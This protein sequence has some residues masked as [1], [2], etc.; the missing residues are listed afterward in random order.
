MLAK[1]VDEDQQNWSQQLP[2]VLMANRSSVHESTGYTPHFLVFG[3][4]TSL[5]LDLMFSPPNSD[6]P[7]TVHDFVQNRN[8]A[9]RKAYELVRKSSTAQQRRR[10]ALYN[11]RVHGPTYQEHE[12]V[13]WHYPVVKAGRSPKLASPWRGPYQIIKCLSDVNYLIEEV[14]TKKQQ[15]VHY[16]RLK[17]YHGTS[18]AL[19]N[20]PERNVTTS[21]IHNEPLGR[22]D[23]DDHEDCESYFAPFPNAYPEPLQQ[24]TMQVSPSSNSVPTCATSVP[25]QQ[26]PTAVPSAFTPWQPELHTNSLHQPSVTEFPQPI[27]SSP[28]RSEV[29]DDLTSTATLDSLI[30]NAARNLKRTHTV[31]NQTRSSFSEHST[32]NN[33]DLTSARPATSKSTTTSPEFPQQTRTF[34]QS[35]QNQRNAAPLYKAKIPNSFTEFVSQRSSTKTSGKKC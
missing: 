11:K 27:F 10:N 26:T 24:P 25:Q 17:R 19:T 8:D 14:S 35:T 32:T 33:A 31:P 20:V 1:C 7:T 15:I 5:P 4:E 9:F 18:A 13:L 2:Y 21:E 16:D 3:T 6:D 23:V 34:R 29:C 22:C 30:T 28:L 12:M